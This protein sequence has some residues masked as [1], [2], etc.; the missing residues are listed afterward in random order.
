MK[1]KIE[2]ILPG[3]GKTTFLKRTINM[4]QFCDRVRQI[5]KEIKLYL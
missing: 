2:V 1:T 3:A 4:L 5:A